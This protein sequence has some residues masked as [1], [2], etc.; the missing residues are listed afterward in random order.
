MI[1]PFYTRITKNQLNLPKPL[2]KEIDVPLN[3]VQNAIYSALA[4]KT[5]AEMTEI[6]INDKA[7][8]RRWRQN[9]IIRLLQAASNPSLL[10]EYSEEFRIPPLSVDGLSV[11]SLIE[12]Y[13]Q[14]EIP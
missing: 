13:T 11:V 5:L 12:N 8:L 4:A 9:K 1:Q 3:R 14:Y 6:S 2:F 7:Q 10:T